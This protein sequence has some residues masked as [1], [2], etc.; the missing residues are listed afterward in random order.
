MLNAD[1]ARVFDEMADLLEIQ[2]ANG[3]RVR[4]YPNAARAIEDS[5]DEIA[6]IAAG[7]VKA[8]NAV[9]GIGKDLA[10]KIVA[11]VETGRVEQLEELGA[12][13]PPGVLV[14]QIKKTGAR[15]V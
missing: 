3:F 13:V 11:L 1:I 2:G 10:A 8:L 4:A 6:A 14:L 15:Y 12:E 7:G 5:A 9:P